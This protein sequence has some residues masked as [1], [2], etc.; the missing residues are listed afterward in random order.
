MVLTISAKQLVIKKA[1][2]T[3]TLIRFHNYEANKE[4][5]SIYL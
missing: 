1:D 5:R 2:H 3:I 4:L